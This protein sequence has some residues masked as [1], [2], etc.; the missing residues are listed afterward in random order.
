M[1]RISLSTWVDRLGKKREERKELEAKLKKIKEEERVIEDK[2][3]D[4]CSK[5]EISAIKGRQWAISLT[6]SIVPNV[7]DWNKFNKYVIRNKAID[8]LQRR[9]STSAWRERVEAGK[10]IPGVEPF[11]RIGL[12]LRKVK[13]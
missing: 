8:M 7:T 12:Q 10:N 4:N 11:T 1:A 13:K 2:I 6:R 3:L 5:D 9:V